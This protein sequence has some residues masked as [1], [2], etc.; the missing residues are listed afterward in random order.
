MAILISVSV[1]FNNVLLEHRSDPVPWIRPHLPEALSGVELNCAHLCP[2]QIYHSKTKSHDGC[3]LPITTKRL[4]KVTPFFYLGIGWRHPKI[5]Q[6]CP[7]DEGCF[8]VQSYL[9]F[10]ILYYFCLM[11]SLLH[12]A[13]HII[14]SLIK[15]IDHCFIIFYMIFQH[16]SHVLPWLCLIF[17]AVLNKV[18]FLISL[19]DRP[20]LVYKN[21]T[22]FA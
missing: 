14:I 9:D 8:K 4:Y 7:N 3:E 5:T 15:G 20:L 11:L 19:S 18:T 16:I 17:Y 13:P 6:N 22:T 2:C 12:Q 1:S 21:V 10:H